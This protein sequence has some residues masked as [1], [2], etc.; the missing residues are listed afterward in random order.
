MECEYFYVMKQPTAHS[1]GLSVYT[2]FHF[3]SMFHIPSVT[4]YKGLAVHE[5]ILLFLFFQIFCWVI[6]D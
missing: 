1:C 2:L 6:L 5:N 3:N 4:L